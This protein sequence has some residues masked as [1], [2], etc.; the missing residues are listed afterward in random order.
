MPSCDPTIFRDRRAVRLRA[1]PLEAVILP[2]GGHLASLRLD[3]LDVNP[4]WEPP[5]PS[6]EP[7]DFDLAK[8]AAAYG[9]GEGRLLASLAGHNLCLDHFG[10]LSPAE[11]DAGA[12]FHGEAPNNSW[13]VHKRA[14]DASGARVT[15]GLECPD[16]GVRFTRTIRLHEGLPVVAFEEEVVNLRRRDAP[17]SWQQ[18]VTLGPP[19]VE[20]GVTT[21]D[22]PATRGWTYPRP[23]GAGDLLQTDREF[24]WPTSPGA[25]GKPLPLNVYPPGPGCSVSAVL[26]EPEA[27]GPGWFAACNPKLG[28]LIAYIFDAALYPWTA[29]WIENRATCAP[30]WN[31][32][33]VTWGIEFG[34]T[35]MPVTRI[36]TLSAGPL[37]GR[38]RFAVLPAK[39]TLRTRFTATLHRIPADW[40][41]VGGVLHQED[42]ITI[43][44]RGDARSLET[45]TE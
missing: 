12:G 31:G 42:R 19:F 5:W 24:R 39:G 45:R 23:V 22:L 43:R 30:P 9:P 10:D 26:L 20:P 2:G 34:T 15:Y 8:H 37:A 38:R 11:I 40:K 4:L 36:E 1:A 13:S 41:G 21:L 6:I 16:A 27:G 18:H 44:E 32:K 7:E 17:L 33:A 35:P 14:A 3:G 25:S 28:L 29:L